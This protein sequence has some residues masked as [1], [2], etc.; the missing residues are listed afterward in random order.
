MSKK[1]TYR[2]NDEMDKWLEEQAKK[3]GTTKNDILRELVYEKMKP[4]A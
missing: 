1:A 2:F 3:K 4:T